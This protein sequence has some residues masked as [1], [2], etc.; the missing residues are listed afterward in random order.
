MTGTLPT[1]LLGCL[2]VG[3]MIAMTPAL[4]THLM[5]IAQGGQTLVAASNHSAFNLANALGPWLSGIAVA[6]GY[7]WSSVGYVGAAMTLTAL[8][9]YFIGGV[10]LKKKAA[11]AG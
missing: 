5:D 4:Q 8:V 1:I 9:I 2:L 6:A 11:P 7:G 3:T 10:L